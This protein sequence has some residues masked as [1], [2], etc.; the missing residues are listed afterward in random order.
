MAFLYPQSTTIIFLNPSAT[1]KWHL[2]PSFTL[3]DLSFKV[4][5]SRQYDQ[6][7]EFSSSSRCSH[8]NI[9]LFSPICCSLLP[10]RS[11]NHWFRRWSGVWSTVWQFLSRF[12]FRQCNWLFC[13]WQLNCRGMS[14]SNNPKKA[15]WAFF[16]NLFIHKP[17]GS[18][19]QL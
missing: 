13:W 2:K 1:Y 7:C 15:S 4:L 6:K 3:L 5:R 11:A 17:L 18:F 14:P 19:V 9:L 12:F 8:R 16:R 10:A